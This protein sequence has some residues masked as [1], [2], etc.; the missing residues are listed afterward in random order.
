M[1]SVLTFLCCCYIG[2]LRESKKALDS[3]LHAVDSGFLELCSR[4]QNP[5][6]LPCE[7]RL[8]FRGMS[9]RAKSRLLF[10]RQLI[11]RKCCLCSQGKDSGST[12]GNSSILDSRS[13][14]L[15][16]SEIR[17]PLHG[18]NKLFQRESLPKT[19]RLRFEGK[20]QFPLNFAH[21]FI[22]VLK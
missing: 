12:S 20:N 3:G 14:N 7:Q 13:K 18:K 2:A 10:A 19:G 5:R 22:L 11:P 21:E 16:D 9:W 17:N 4:F 6:F 8:H 15:R 1:E